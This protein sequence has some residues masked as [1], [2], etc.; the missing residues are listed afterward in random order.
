MIADSLK[1][2]SPRQ[3]ISLDEAN[4]KPS[5]TIS[6]SPVPTPRNYPGMTCGK[7]LE[8][9]EKLI[10]NSTD[11]TLSPDEQIQSVVD[12]RYLI[13]MLE[14]FCTDKELKSKGYKNI[15]DAKQKLRGKL[16]NNTFALRSHVPGILARLEKLPQTPVVKKAIE[17]GERFLIISAVSNPAILGVATSAGA[18][19]L[20]FQFFKS[21]GPL[22]GWG[23]QY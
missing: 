17:M 4:L 23:Q 1:I 13:D 6:Y 22:L 15:D 21:V 11:S 2:L 5:F 10:K 7:A 18:G 12:A 20:L 16:D 3:I 9:I 19:Y 8:T 14:E